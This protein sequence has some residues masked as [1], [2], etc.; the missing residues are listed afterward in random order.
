MSLRCLRQIIGVNSNTMTSNQTW[1]KRKKIPFGR[2]CFKYILRVNA[3]LAK[4]LRQFIDKGYIDVTLRVFNHFGCFRHFHCWGQMGTCSNY[5]GI[6]P[7]YFYS[8][9]WS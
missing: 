7:V 3:H 6:D 2:S 8:H 5:R 9:L 4:Y 1:F